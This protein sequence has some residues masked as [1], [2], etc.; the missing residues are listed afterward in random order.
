ML[1]GILAFWL[2]LYLRREMA[3]TILSERPC[4]LGWVIA[5]SF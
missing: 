1:R 2:A 4:L 3:R 5:G